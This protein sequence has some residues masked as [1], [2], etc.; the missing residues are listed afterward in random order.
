V[1]LSN[2]G[3]RNLDYVE[4]TFEVLPEIAAAVGDRTTVIVDSGIRRGSDIVKAIALGANAVLA[5]RATLYGTAAGG[6]RGRRARSNCC[7]MRWITRW[8][9]SA[10]R[11]LP[12][13]A[14]RHWRRHIEC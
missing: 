4:S 6:R 5:G 3:G 11:P 14:P 13:L 8:R 12:T 10:A 1:V 2:H 7:T 9:C